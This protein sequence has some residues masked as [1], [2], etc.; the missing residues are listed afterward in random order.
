MDDGAVANSVAGVV[1][2]AVVIGDGS[3]D[4]KYYRCVASMCCYI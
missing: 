2:D 1:S 3:T 4:W